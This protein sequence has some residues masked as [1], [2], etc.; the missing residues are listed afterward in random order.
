[1]VTRS[2]QLAQ[3]PAG[4]QKVLDLEKINSNTVGISISTEK[5]LSFIASVNLVYSK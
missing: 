5:L 2:K 3:S 1:M 4:D